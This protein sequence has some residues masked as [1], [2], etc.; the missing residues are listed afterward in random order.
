MVLKTYL[1]SFLNKQFNVFNVQNGEEA[2]AFLDKKIPDLVITDW[3]MPIKNGYEL[4][5]DLKRHSDYQNIP[6][7]MLTARNLISDYIRILKLGA[8][9]YL[10]KP[11]D[12]NVLLAKII[13]L[14]EHGDSFNK[15]NLPSLFEKNIDSLQTE[16]SLS[17]SD[18]DWLLRLEKSILPVISDF[19]L[20]LKII[21]DTMDVSLTTLKNKIKSITG[22][23]A[24]RYV[25]EL[26]FWEARRMLEEREIQ[27]V[28]AICFSVGFKQVKNFS[29]NF[30]KR[31]GKYPSEYL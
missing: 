24:M 5:S 26:R 17:E 4:I 9:A 31:F 29:R 2:I 1:H 15:S 21:A 7:I 14:S 10:T 23:T 3:M 25:Q 27:S 28:K 30:K 16:V 8:G 22:I 13:V 11:I 12:E 18:Q 20:S 19:D 6:I